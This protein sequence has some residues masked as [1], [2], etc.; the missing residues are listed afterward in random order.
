MKFLNPFLYSIL[1]LTLFGCHKKEIFQP[2]QTSKSDYLKE[3]QEYSK[4]REE[5]E[6]K[7]LQKWVNKQKDSLNHVFE[8]ANSGIWIRFIERKNQPVA[9]LHDWVSYT[10]EI[11]TLSNEIIY[12]STEFGTKEGIIGKFK[13]IRGIETALYMMGKGDVAEL[14]LPSFTA[15]GLYGD[16][17]KIG[18]NVPLVVELHLIDVK[19]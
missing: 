9:K 14:L 1:I 19:N 6:R 3:S 8:P 16:E 2:V 7:Y 17:N 11:K 5:S 18:A 13:D 15:Y 12:T 4:S 10:A